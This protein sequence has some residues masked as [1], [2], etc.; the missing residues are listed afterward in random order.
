MG[1]GWVALTEEMPSPE[2]GK[3]SP[4]EPFEVV[5]YECADELLAVVEKCSKDCLHCAVTQTWGLSISDCVRFQFK[6]D[7]LEPALPQGKVNF[8]GC[9]YDAE[10]V[11][12]EF[13]P[14]W[15]QHKLR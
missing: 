1:E 7:L 14:F 15:R 3:L 9:L 13:K 4:I 6:F 5:C 12:A 2:D 10:V 11:L 8:M